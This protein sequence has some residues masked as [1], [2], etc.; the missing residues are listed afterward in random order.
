MYPYE[1]VFNRG[2]GPV[3]RFPDRYLQGQGQERGEGVQRV[4]YSGVRRGKGA[5]HRALQSQERGERPHW[6]TRGWRL[7]QVGQKGAGTLGLIMEEST[8]NVVRLAREQTATGEQDNDLG[9]HQGWFR[10]RAREE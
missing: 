5:V 10:L 9:S 2:R 4:L 3:N 8:D 1:R 7:Q 6:N